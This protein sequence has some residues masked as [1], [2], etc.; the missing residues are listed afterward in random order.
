MDRCGCSPYGNQGALIAFQKDQFLIGNGR[1]QC[2]ATAQ[3]DHRFDASFGD[4]ASPTWLADSLAAEQDA[5]EQLRGVHPDRLTGE[6][7]DVEVRP[8]QMV[9]PLKI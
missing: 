3:G 6:E 5:L 7:F 2:E 4:Y 1:G 8:E 9:G